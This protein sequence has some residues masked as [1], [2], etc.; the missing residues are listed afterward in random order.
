MRYAD[1][2]MWLISAVT[3]YLKETG[4]MNFLDKVIPYLEKDEGTV[5]DHLQ[6][7]MKA[8]GTERGEHG[9]CLIWEGDWNDSLTHIG[10]RGR[11]ESIW[12]SQAFCYACLCMEEL[13]LFVG[14]EKQ[15]EDYKKQY[16]TMKDNLNSNAW[17]GDWYIRA[18]NDDGVPIGSSKNREGQIYLN[19]QS[20]AMISRTLPV[21]KKEQIINSIDDRLFTPFG[22][23]LL[24]PVYTAKDEQI[25]R[26]TC[27]EPGTCENASVY[28]HGNA[29]LAMGL[30]LE[31]ESDR[32]FKVLKTIMPYNRDNPSEHIIPY[33]VSNGYAGPGHRTEPGRAEHA[34]VTGSVAW[35][36]FFMM[37]YLLGLR[38]HYD[39]LHVVPNI[40]SEWEKASMTRRYRDTVYRYTC[41]R[42]GKGSEVVQLTV[43]AETWDA[44]K[45]LPVLH[46][47][48][49]IVNAVIR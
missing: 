24:D 3:E 46:G 14:K 11:G 4:E 45:P 15:A 33:Q 48:T 43:N 1:S 18:F 23:T 36:H 38:R 25:G 42:Q 28:T 27:I 34:W 21:E 8:L 2:A 20:W 16:Q 39:G 17:D 12:L 22:Y 32:A 5:Y 13:S 49:V 44:E 35:L 9:L 29:F 47:E 6:R 19:S 26:I 37:D 10:R 41:I 40:P 30:F 7:A 31:G